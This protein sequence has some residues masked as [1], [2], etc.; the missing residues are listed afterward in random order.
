MMA[1]L[2]SFIRSSYFHPE[3]SASFAPVRRNLP[4]ADLI[5]LSKRLR[6]EDYKVEE[7]SEYANYRLL[8]LYQTKELKDLLLSKCRN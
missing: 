3:Y 5:F 2:F 4:K 8:A 1:I 6:T 7:K